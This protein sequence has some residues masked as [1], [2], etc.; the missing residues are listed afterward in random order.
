MGVIDEEKPALGEMAQEL[1][2]RCQP[3]VHTEGPVGQ[4]Q[5]MPMG[6]TVHQRHGAVTSPAP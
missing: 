2:N 4:D 1:G 5:R 6:V 3:T